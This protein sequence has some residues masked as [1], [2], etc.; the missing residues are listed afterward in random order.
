MKPA[1]VE[2]T[3]TAAVGCASHGLG[4]PETCDCGHPSFRRAVSVPYMRGRFQD[5]HTTS[6]ARLPSGDAQQAAVLLASLLPASW[7]TADFRDATIEAR[8][9]VGFL[10]PPSPDVSAPPDVSMPPDFSV[11]PDVSTPP[12]ASPSR[13]DFPQSLL[14]T[15]LPPPPAH[16]SPTARSQQA[17]N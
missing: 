11:P 10:A 16:S 14:Y 4:S 8:E 2:L 13:Y 15:M 9:D 1:C 5:K 17:L 3:V 12:D 6:P 7:L